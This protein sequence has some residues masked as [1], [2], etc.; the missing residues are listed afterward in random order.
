[1]NTIYVVCGK[2]HGDLVSP[3][4]GPG[5]DIFLLNDKIVVVVTVSPQVVSHPL[6]Q[7]RLSEVIKTHKKV[8]HYMTL[9]LLCIARTISRYS[10]SP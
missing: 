9:L 7:W 5:R 3:T 6:S 1:V 4:V 2:V 10:Q 8:K